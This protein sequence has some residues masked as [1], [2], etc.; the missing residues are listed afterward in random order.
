MFKEDE[1]MKNDDCSN[2]FLNLKMYTENLNKISSYPLLILLIKNISKINA[3]I[4]Q[5]FDESLMKA[6]E[7]GFFV[8]RNLVNG[9]RSED[10]LIGAMPKY[11]SLGYDKSN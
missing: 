5:N 11:V 1:E 4:C 2:E 3:E 7:F 8:T 6:K 10:I 9:F